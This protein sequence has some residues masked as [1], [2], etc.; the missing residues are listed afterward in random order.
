MGGALRTQVGAEIG[1][2]EERKHFLHKGVD[3]ESFLNRLL[4]P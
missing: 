2:G 4:P 3:S 1:E